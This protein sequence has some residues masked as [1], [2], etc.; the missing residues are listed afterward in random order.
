VH[1]LGLELRARGLP[2]Q[3]QEQP[4]GACATTALWSALSRVVRADGGRAPTPHSV[5][6]AATRHYLED[7]ALPA[8]SGL[9]LAQLTAAIRELGYSPYVLKPRSEYATFVLSLKCYLRSEIPAVLVLQ[10]SQGE[11]HGRCVWLSAGG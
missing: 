4:V 10:D 8:V 7:R 2:F 6:Q 5:T 1:L 9:E 3:Q 11:Y